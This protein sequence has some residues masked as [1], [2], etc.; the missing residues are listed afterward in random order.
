MKKTLTICILFLTILTISLGLFL[1]IFLP[2][3]LKNQLIA[4]GKLLLKTDVNISSINISL[5]GSLNIKDI[6]IKNPSDFSQNDFLILKNLSF[7]IRPETLFKETIY[8]ENVNLKNADILVELNDRM[9]INI[10]ELSKQINTPKESASEK[11]KT[12]KF[13][14]KFII[15]NFFIVSPT[16]LLSSKKL[17]INKNYKLPDIKIVDIGV[18]ENGLRPEEIV[19]GFLT[20]ISE[21]S[22]KYTLGL[23]KNLKDYYSKKKQKLIDDIS[24]E[25]KK[26]KGIVNDVKNSLKRFGIE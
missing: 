11:T 3:I 25:E 23:T 26:L 15:E 12:S 14:K 16:L 5:D 1:K 24:K 20:R 6:R 10:A 19:T 18:K 8:V 21:E 4:N 2:D 7:K 13:E 9:Q 22:E 17:S